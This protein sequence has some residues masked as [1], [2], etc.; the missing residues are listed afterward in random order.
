MQRQNVTLSLPKE[1]IK[2][3]KIIAIKKDTSLSNLMR[4]A[5]EETVESDENYQKAMNR[6]LEILEE[7][8]NLNLKGKIPWTRE[9]LHA[10]KNLS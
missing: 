10:R 5:L 8:F 1:L 3:A 2:K 4:Q 7:G 6:H 9:E